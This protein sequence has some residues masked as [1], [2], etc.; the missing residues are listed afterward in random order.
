MYFLSSSTT[1]QVAVIHFPVNSSNPETFCPGT[2]LTHSMQG[3]NS[4]TADAH[5][6]AVPALDT[7]KL[8][9]RQKVPA[10]G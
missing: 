3:I 5:G 6:D 10:L 7:L 1:L 8:D 9:Y 4:N 2:R